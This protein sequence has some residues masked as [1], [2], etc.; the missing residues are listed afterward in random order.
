MHIKAFS[1]NTIFFFFFQVSERSSITFRNVD[2]KPQGV[3]LNFYLFYFVFLQTKRI[4]W[5]YWSHFV[6]VTIKKKNIIGS[7]SCTLFM[8]NAFSLRV[9]CS[10]GVEFSSVIP[11]REN[12]LRFFH[13]IYCTNN[14][15]PSLSLPN[16]LPNS[17]TTRSGEI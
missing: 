14:S 4:E 10:F 6:G 5:D 7:S 2:C 8:E 16:S 9:N 12:T 1:T 17:Y 11:E 15:G 3:K 13:H